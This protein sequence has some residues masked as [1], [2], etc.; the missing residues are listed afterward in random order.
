MLRNR[1]FSDLVHSY[2]IFFRIDLRSLN[3]N[4]KFQNNLY[5]TWDAV[6]CKERSFLCIFSL[7]STYCL[8]TPF[9]TILS[10]RIALNWSVVLLSVYQAYSHSFYSQTI[11]MLSRPPLQGS[12]FLPWI[13]HCVVNLMFPGTGNVLINGGKRTVW[14]S[15]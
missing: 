10:W 6:P 11:D 15:H 2:G 4:L 9:W 13:F 3:W 8:V 12:Q 14:T 1:N 5:K 7:S